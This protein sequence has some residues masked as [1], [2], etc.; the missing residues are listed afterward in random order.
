MIRQ[1]LCGP[2]GRPARCLANG[3]VAD[4]AGLGLPLAA[5]VPFRMVHALRLRRWLGAPCRIR[6]LIPVLR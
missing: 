2:V 6:T 3:S 1:F 4:W 5:G